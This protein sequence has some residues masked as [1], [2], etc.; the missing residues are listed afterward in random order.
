M[1]KT[2]FLK[3]KPKTIGVLNGPDKS[4]NLYALY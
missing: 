1:I 3:K 2:K 4:N